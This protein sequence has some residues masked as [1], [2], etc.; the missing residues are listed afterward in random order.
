M[1]PVEDQDVVRKAR[2][3]TGSQG[4]R[5]ESFEDFSRK[6]KR[7]LRDTGQWERKTSKERRGKS[8]VTRRLSSLR[9]R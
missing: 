3:V 6:Y 1:A 4:R 9:S 8:L 7:Y 5:A 2:N